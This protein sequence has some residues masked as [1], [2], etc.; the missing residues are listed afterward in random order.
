MALLEEERHRFPALAETLRYNWFPEEELERRREERQLADAILCASSFYQQSLI[1]TGADAEKIFVEPYGVDQTVFA[2]SKEKFPI[3]LSSGQVLTRRLKALGICSKLS[4]AS[5]CRASSWFWRVILMESDAVAL[6]EDR[7]RVRRLG[8]ISRQEV[9]K[10]MG[11]CHAH[12]FPTL[13]RRFGRNIIEA[14]A[15]GLPVITT[16]KLRGTGFDRRRCDRLYRSHTRCGRDLRKARLDLR[17]SAGCNRD[18]RARQR[19]AS[20]V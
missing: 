5:L 13:A 9:G 8:H 6:Y 4:R 18:G 10:M 15:S 12:V 17:S 2:P 1:E 3:S 19:R 7:I 20:R 14:M 16:A 11:R